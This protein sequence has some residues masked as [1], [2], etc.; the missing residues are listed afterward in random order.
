MRFDSLTII[1]NGSTFCF[2]LSTFSFFPRLLASGPARS[3]RITAPLDASG[4]LA[5]EQPLPNRSHFHGG[6]QF[7]QA[8]ALVKGQDQ[9]LASARE[10]ARLRHPFGLPRPVEGSELRA[11]LNRQ[12]IGD[13][14]TFPE[15]PVARVR[16]I[17]P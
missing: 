11:H 3:R 17:R 9:R 15:V 10:A 1:A 7:P 4:R 5:G 8:V 6:V 13:E 16:D 12:G 14:I 2:Q